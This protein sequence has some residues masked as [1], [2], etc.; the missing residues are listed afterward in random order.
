[1]L[2]ILPHIRRQIGETAG[3]LLKY[4]SEQQAANLEWMYGLPLYNFLMGKS[5]PFDSINS[6]SV[7]V[8]LGNWKNLTQ[9]LI[10]VRK[11]VAG[12]HQLT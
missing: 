7:D 2:R 8:L 9:T 11:K 10:N 3:R 4:I 5:Y 1:M 6:M 12:N